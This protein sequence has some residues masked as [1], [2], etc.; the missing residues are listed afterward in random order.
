[1]GFKVRGYKREVTQDKVRDYRLFAIAC[2]G[3]VPEP[4]KTKVYLLAQALYD[5]IGKPQFEKFVA[6]LPKLEQEMLKNKK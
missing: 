2:E 1:M 5:R 3:T 4:L 6:A